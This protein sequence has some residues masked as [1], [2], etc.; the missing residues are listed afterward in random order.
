M[1]KNILQDLEIESVEEGRPVKPVPRIPVPASEICTMD[2]LDANLD[3]N[4]VNFI[5]NS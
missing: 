2:G 5:D 1:K 4:Q 3:Y